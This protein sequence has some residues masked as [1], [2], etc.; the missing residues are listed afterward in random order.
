MTRRRELF[1]N[2]LI[3]SVKYRR[4]R[5]RNATGKCGRPFHEKIL[6][7]YRFQSAVLRPRRGLR[8][9]L[10]GLLSRPKIA[11]DRDQRG[12]LP[13]LSER[14]ARSGSRTSERGRPLPSLDPS[15]RGD[16]RHRTITMAHTDAQHARRAATACRDAQAAPEQCTE[17]AGCARNASA[18][19]CA[20]RLD[21]IGAKRQRLGQHQRRRGAVDGEP[22]PAAWA[23]LGGTSD[24][25]HRPQRVRRD[26]D[27]QEASPARHAARRSP[28]SE[29]ASTKLTS[30]PQVS[31]KLLRQLRIPQYMTGGPRHGADRGSGT[32]CSGRHPRRGHQGGGT[33]LERGQ[34]CLRLVVARVVGAPVAPRAAIPGCRDRAETSSRC[35][36]AGRRHRPSRRSTQHLRRKRCGLE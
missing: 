27:P 34:Q 10:R 12:Y 28:L 22:A 15:R 3:I 36:L 7:H 11:A 17:T 20:A 9:G 8:G 32:G 16:R 14:D 26:L 5:S 29:V 33:A 24:V 35:A 31:A 1:V 13:P 21:E 23:I 2:F 25:S 6:T 18:I 30:V 4:S 19:R